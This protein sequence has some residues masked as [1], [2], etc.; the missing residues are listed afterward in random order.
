MKKRFLSLI[1]LLIL[2]LS[3]ALVGLTSCGDDNDKDD[4]KKS[5]FGNSD[6]IELPIVDWEPDEE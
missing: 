4:D 1:L 3:I 5:P 2:T 6:G